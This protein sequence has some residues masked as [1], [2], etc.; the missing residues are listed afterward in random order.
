MII[1]IIDPNPGLSNEIWI[2]FMKYSWVNRNHELFMNI[3]TI[4]LFNKCSWTFMNVY[5]SNMNFMNNFFSKFYKKIAMEWLPIL[6]NKWLMTKL[7]VKSWI[8]SCHDSL[9]S[10]ISEMQVTYTT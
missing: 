5:E 1:I 9:I 3:I 6:N 8:H 2:L 7:H 10:T 4:M